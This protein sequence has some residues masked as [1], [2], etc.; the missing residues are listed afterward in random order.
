[1][2]NYIFILCLFFVGMSATQ[3]M[4]QGLIKKLPDW[5]WK[6]S[7][8]ELKKNKD[9]FPEEEYKKNLDYV[10]EYALDR[11]EQRKGKAEDREKTKRR[12]L[13][14]AVSGS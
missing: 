11:Y 5:D 1:M 2:N 8:R 12:L 10:L 9:K 4:E 3:C 6:L 14:H 13:R 7:V